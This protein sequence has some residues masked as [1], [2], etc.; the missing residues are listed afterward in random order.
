MKP[1]LLKLKAIVV[2][3]LGLPY[4]ILN[5]NP[6]RDY[7]RAF[8]VQGFQVQ[9]FGVYSV[10]KIVNGGA[11]SFLALYISSILDCF[12]FLGPGC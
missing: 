7:Y 10:S 12:C 9:G 4:R 5:M 11:L 2:P 8:Q 1:R 6:K 3:F